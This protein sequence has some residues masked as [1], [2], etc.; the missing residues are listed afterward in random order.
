MSFSSYLF[1]FHCTFWLHSVVATVAFDQVAYYVSE[2]NATTQIV[3]IL[4]I[5]LSTDVTIEIYDTNVT[6]SGKT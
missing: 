1:V 2:N 6:A 3:L 4:D 5:P